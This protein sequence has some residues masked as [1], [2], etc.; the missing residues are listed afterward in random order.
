MEESI[1]I[2]GISMKSIDYKSLVEIKPEVMLAGYT[3]R[4]NNDGLYEPLSEIRLNDPEEF[5]KP[6][7]FR[8]KSVLCLKDGDS[9][10][11]KY[12]MINN[13]GESALSDF[14]LDNPDVRYR[15]V[16]GVYDVPGLSLVGGIL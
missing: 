11:V 9:Y 1:S 10:I 7:E 16:R 15:I 8:F 4:L 2:G 12:L 14:I 13:N 6:D 3:F 5:V